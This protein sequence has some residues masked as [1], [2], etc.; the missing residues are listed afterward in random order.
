MLNRIWIIII[1]ILV[2]CKKTENLSVQEILTYGNGTWL[3][4]DDF[5]QEDFSFE[6]NG[7]LTAH[8]TGETISLIGKGKY[9]IEGDEV[10][11]NIEKEEN[12]SIDKGSFK[13]NLKC[14][15][16]NQKDD[17]QYEYKLSCN[18]KTD[19][20]S[21]A[22]MSFDRVKKY[23]GKYDVLS[24]EIKKGKTIDNANF[25]TEPSEKGKLISCTFTKEENGNPIPA[26]KTFIP[27]DRDINI[28]AKTKD[29]FKVQKWE[30]YW[31]YISVPVSGYIGE[32]C[33][34]GWVY[35]EF[36]NF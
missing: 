16:I 28:I 24:L 15:L 8:H 36:I 18:N 19:Y 11:L 9:K 13:K 35:G 32:Q 33:S 23:L 26:V 22:L 27:K 12:Q 4:S 1:L 34:K 30:N 21:R 2:S 6:S 14:K 3:F 25:R 31:Y 17:L 29:K 20:Y 10:I 7:N 5:N